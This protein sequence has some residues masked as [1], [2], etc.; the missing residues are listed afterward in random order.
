MP[1]IIFLGFA[2]VG[3]LTMALQL[4]TGWLVYSVTSDIAAP[5]REEQARERQVRIFF[6]AMDIKGNDSWSRG[7]TL[8]V[9][10]DFQNFHSER[11]LHVATLVSISDVTDDGDAPD[12]ELLK[13]FAQATSAQLANAECEMLT[14]TELVAKCRVARSTGEPSKD[15]RLEISFSLEFVPNDGFGDV[16]KVDKAALVENM[17]KLETGSSQPQKPEAARNYRAKLYSKAA[18]FCAKMKAKFG[19]CAVMSVRIDA[20]RDSKT[21]ARASF[22]RLMPL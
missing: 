21:V 17:E 8:Q 6:G 13:A 1:R 11:T 20:T 3:V 9:I 4:H 22:A 19:N 14:R 2:I 15:N 12:K 5:Y 16:K 18:Q 10:S 7:P